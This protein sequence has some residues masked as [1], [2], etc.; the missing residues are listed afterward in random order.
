VPFVFYIRRLVHLRDSDGI[1]DQ[2]WA[3][4]VIA[5]DA[6]EVHRG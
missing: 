1:A 2:G 6:V 5:I 4:I 3:L